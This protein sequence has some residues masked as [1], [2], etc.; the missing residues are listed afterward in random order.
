MAVIKS[1][2]FE[3]CDVFHGLST[4]RSK[5]KERRKCRY[6]FFFTLNN[7]HPQT[8]THAKTKTTSLKISKM[9]NSAWQTE[10]AVKFFFNFK[11]FLT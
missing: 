11:E 10:R 9:F 6:F 4:L 2:N 8:Q 3:P 5:S 7:V 1:L